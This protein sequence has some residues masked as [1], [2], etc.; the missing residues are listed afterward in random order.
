[1]FRKR[2]DFYKIEPAIVHM[3]QKYNAGAVIVEVSGVGAA[4][5]EALLKREASRQW[6]FPL[7]PDVGKVERALAQTPK[8][9]RKRVYLPVSA[10]WLET[11]EAEVATFPNAFVDFFD[12]KA[13]AGNDIL[14][15]RRPSTKTSTRRSAGACQSPPPCA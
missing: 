6:F 11:F 3:K 1:M 10:P 5:G 14:R 9:E 8:I 15:A 7:N 13:L 2:L 12:S 4:I